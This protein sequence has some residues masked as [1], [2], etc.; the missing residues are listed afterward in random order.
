MRLR[1][2]GR[3]LLV[4]RAGRDWRVFDVGEGK[5]RP[6]TDVRL[7]GDIRADEVVLALADLLHE[8]ASARYPD[9]ELLDADR[10]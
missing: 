7:P 8:Y 3:E 6:A 10:E 5:R 2:Y 9:V 1:V 4:E